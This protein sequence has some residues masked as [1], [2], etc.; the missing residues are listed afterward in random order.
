MHPHLWLPCAGPHI[1]STAAI[2]APDATAAIAAI[3]AYTLPSPC[4]PPPPPPARAH[5]CVFVGKS[6]FSNALASSSSRSWVRVNQDSIGKGGKRG[7][8]QQCISAAKAALAA[9][10]NVI[11]DRWGSHSVMFGCCKSG[12][13]DLQHPASILHM[14]HCACLCVRDC[15]G[16]QGK[17]QQQYQHQ[18]RQH[19]AVIS[20]Q[21][22]QNAYRV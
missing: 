9:G 19:G 5:T 16:V 13:V 7:T 4:L 20:P 18:H 6:T 2:A 3:A 8:R 17:Q 1:T 21:C 10:R 22:V 12:L 15:V 14:M 11:I